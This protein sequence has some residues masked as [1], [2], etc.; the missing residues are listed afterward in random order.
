[1]NANGLACRPA[2]IEGAAI[3]AEN[4]HCGSA[5]NPS[6]IIS[7]H[8]TVKPRGKVRLPVGPHV[9]QIAPLQCTPSRCVTQV[10][11][12][13]EIAGTSRHRVSRMVPAVLGTVTFEWQRE[14]VSLGETRPD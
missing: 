8:Q 5:G 10:I 6:R 12:G 9:N 11:T 7:H 2:A 1:M 14:E 4:R 3:V 13:E